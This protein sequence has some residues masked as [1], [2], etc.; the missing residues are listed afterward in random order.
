MNKALIKFSI[1]VIA[2]TS[3]FFVLHITGN[4]NNI[5]IGIFALIWYIAGLL[6]AEVDNENNT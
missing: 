1:L 5:P 3:A 2:T 4:E 6:V